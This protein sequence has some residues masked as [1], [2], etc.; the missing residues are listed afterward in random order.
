MDNLN[1]HCSESVIR[2]VARK[3]GYRADLGIK[4][5]SGILKSMATCEA[6]LR[7]PSH[8]IVI[9]YTSKH[10][11]WLNQIEIGISILARKVIR[12]GNFTSTDDL[13]NA[14]WWRRP[15]LRPL[16]LRQ[17]DLQ[18]RQSITCPRL[19][20]QQVARHVSDSP[21][22][23]SNPRVN[24]SSLAKQQATRVPME[25]CLNSTL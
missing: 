18:C 23:G 10:G 5:K 3:I 17:A 15:W 20:L 1:T 16:E 11:S 9:H 12:R 14:R 4:G 7:D 19:V 2:L 24:P 6:F 22:A 13:S 25:P 21:I 8:R